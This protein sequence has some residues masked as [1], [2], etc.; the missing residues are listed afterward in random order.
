MSREV[1]WGLPRANGTW[2]IL[3]MPAPTT[4][5][6]LCNDP[7]SKHGKEAM[8]AL[9]DPEIANAKAAPPCAAVEVVNSPEQAAEKTRW[10]A[11]PLPLCNRA[12]LQSCRIPRISA[13][14]LASAGICF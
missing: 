12:R 6:W 5:K 8:K 14:A 3:R 10:A 13:W 11:N 2:A 4:R 1:Y 9:K 7:D